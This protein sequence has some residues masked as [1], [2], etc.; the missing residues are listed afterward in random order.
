MKPSNS[1]EARLNSPHCRLKF[2]VPRAF[3]E[4]AQDIA[5]KREASE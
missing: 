5:L 4:G 1:L 2:A 3:G